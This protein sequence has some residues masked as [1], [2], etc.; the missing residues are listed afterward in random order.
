MASV[1]QHH[2][3]PCTQASDF[4]TFPP[5]SVSSAQGVWLN[6][7]QHG[8][9]LDA[10]SSWWCKHLGHRHP[11]LVDA[12]CTQSKTL[13]HALGANTA[14]EAT[15]E[16]SSRLAGLMPNLNKVFYA[17]DGS[18]AVEIALKMALHAKQ[19]QG[20]GH[21]QHVMH[22]K[23]AYHGETIMAMAVSDCDAYK[24]PYA[25]WMPKAHTIDVV[26]Y[27]DGESDPIWRDCGA[28][29]DDVAPFLDTHGDACCAIIVEPLLQGANHMSIYSKD[30]LRRL[31]DWAKCRGVYL[32]AD[33]IMTGFWRTGS[34]L[35]CQQAGVVP[36]FVCLGKGL[37]S[38][39]LPIS[40]VL[41]H[42]AIYELFYGPKD[43]HPGFLHSHTFSGHALSAA[44]ANAAMA[45]YESMP[46]V[47]MVATL[48][49]AMRQSFR[50]IDAQLSC[51]QNIRQLGGMV[52]A[53]LRPSFCQHPRSG[54]LLQQHCVRH[55][56]L[57]RPLGQTV[58]WC[59]PLNIKVSEVEHL[60]KAT[61]KG[62]CDLQKT[63]P[64]S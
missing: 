53:E 26:P 46:M 54:W 28:I 49:Q 51:F 43:T 45:L 48:G 6:T 27:V 20:E 52:A 61:F 14:S 4:E 64:I 31:A 37:T 30:F 18:C 7:D 29:W 22:L 36:D 33:E 58:Y 34:L 8:P 17:G 15:V 44:V 2:W 47:N 24:A 50:D 3:H 25:T 13:I 63:S 62:L 55:G 59:P 41:A 11:K 40:A 19:M 16:L 9:V 32:I 1:W 23:G 35:A 10:T 21:R 12:L 5:L 38:G 57:I 56:V 42:E 39:M 60:S